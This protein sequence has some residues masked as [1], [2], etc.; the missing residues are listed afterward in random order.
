MPVTT[1]SG[2]LNPSGQTCQ[3]LS[4]S[5]ATF[6]AVPAGTKLALQTFRPSSRVVSPGRNQ[7][8]P[9]VQLL[10]LSH[11]SALSGALNRKSPW[12]LQSSSVDC[13]ELGSVLPQPALHGS[14]TTKTPLG[15]GSKLRAEKRPTFLTAPSS[16]KTKA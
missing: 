13:G 9:F 14:W 11:S 1:Q 2:S 4:L 12:T 5:M 3:T 16:L 10:D 8:L 15:R 7:T 6:I